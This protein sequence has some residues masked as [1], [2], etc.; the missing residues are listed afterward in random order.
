[1]TARRSLILELAITLQL[2]FLQ[3]FYSWPPFSCIRKAP[4]PSERISQLDPLWRFP[5][6]CFLWSRVCD[7]C[8]R[9]GHK[10]YRDRIQRNWLGLRIVSHSISSWWLRRR[11]QLTSRSN[12]IRIHRCRRLCAFFLFLS[13]HRRGRLHWS[14]R[15]RTRP[16]ELSV[17]RFP[18][19]LRGCRHDWT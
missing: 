9:A 17:R 18:S 7:W 16:N 10:C 19:A 4:R 3:S 2:T 13:A 6:H 5:L 1:M 12:R 15:I 8:Y 14:L 11:P